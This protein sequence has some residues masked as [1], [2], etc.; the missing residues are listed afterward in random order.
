MEEKG[1]RLLSKNLQMQPHVVVLATDLTNG[2]SKA[3][4]YAVVHSKMFYKTTSVME[5][6]DICLKSAFVFGIQYP[7]AAHSSWSFLQKAVYG[8]SSRFDRLPSKVLE[9][10]SDVGA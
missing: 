10:I 3:A 8:L 2:L 4:A 5:A 6:V 1:E 7:I 9:L